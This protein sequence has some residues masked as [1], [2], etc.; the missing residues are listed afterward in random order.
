[1]PELQQSLLDPN[2][3]IRPGNRSYQAT[4]TSGATITGRLLNQDSFSIQLLDSSER[5]VSLAKSNL[6]EHGY[7]KTSPMPSYRD[8]LN[9]QEVADLVAALIEREEKRLAEIGKGVL[10]RP[11]I[12]DALRRLKII[13]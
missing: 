6:R 8:K 2:A 10:V 11:E 12:D 13:E 1:M 4:T 7:L 3:T 9:P 5:L